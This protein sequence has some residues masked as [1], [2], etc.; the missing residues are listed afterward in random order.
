MV[1]GRGETSSSVACTDWPARP[2]WS[3]HEHSELHASAS[4]QSQ[5]PPGRVR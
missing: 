2:L 5:Q 4:P 1:G 3:K